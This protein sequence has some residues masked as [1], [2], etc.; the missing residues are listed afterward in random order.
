[1]NHGLAEGRSGRKAEA[2]AGCFTQA[3]EGGSLA[4]LTSEITVSPK[5]TEIW[6]YIGIQ[7]V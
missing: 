6:I 3:L 2:M 4:G 7:K 5:E 1:M